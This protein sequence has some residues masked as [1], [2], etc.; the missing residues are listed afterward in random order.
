MLTEKAK[1]QFEQVPK[2]KTKKQTTVTQVHGYQTAGRAHNA[3]W[4]L[5]HKLPVYTKTTKSKSWFAA[6]WYRVKKGRT[7]S[8]VQDPKLILL[9]RYNYSGPYHT[10]EQ[11]QVPTELMIKS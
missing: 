1:I 5:V 6:G 8:V 2:I 10:Q 4:D 3:M 7:W 11:A 9:Q